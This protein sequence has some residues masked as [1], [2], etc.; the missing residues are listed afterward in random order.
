[1]PAQPF[2]I[3]LSLLEESDERGRTHRLVAIDSEVEAG[4]WRF[5]AEF[6]RKEAHSSIDPDSENP[7]S[8]WHLT[9]SYAA[10][11]IAGIPMTPYARYDTVRALTGLS[12]LTAGVNGTLSRLIVLKLERQQHLSGSGSD[13]WLAQAVVVF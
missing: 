11:S 8:G 13:S 6:V 3:G 9:T 4:Q 10:G 2:E 7:Q 1:V 12:R 5:R